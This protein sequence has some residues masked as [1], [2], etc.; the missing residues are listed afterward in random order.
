[1]YILSILDCV[2]SESLDQV[3]PF[4]SGLACLQP[5]SSLCFNLNSFSVFE[6]RGSS[7]LHGSL[8]IASSTTLKSPSTMLGFRDGVSLILVWILFQKFIISLGAFGE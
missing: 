2:P 5:S 8:S 6:A 1:M 3:Y 4:S 7:G